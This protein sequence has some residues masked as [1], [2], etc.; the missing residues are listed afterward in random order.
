MV[1][2]CHLEV[3]IAARRNHS[4]DAARAIQCRA[5]A[6]RMHHTALALVSKLGRKK[7]HKHNWYFVLC[8][9]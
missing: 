2:V 7:A 6:R 4:L 3:S 1:E 9:G 8:C 5:A